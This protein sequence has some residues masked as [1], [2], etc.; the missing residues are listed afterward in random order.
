MSYTL[1]MASHLG[2]QYRPQTFASILGNNEQTNALQTALQENSLPHALL[3]SG[4]R[5]SGKTTLAR[6]V[7]MALSCLDPQKGQACTE[8]DVC[9]SP[10]PDVV[11]MDAA[12]NRGVD[13]IRAIRERV[14]LM[15]MQARSLV[16]IIDEA[17]MLTREA[18][19]AL[20]KTLEEPPPH[21]YFLLATT[22]P[23]KLLPT[24]RSRC[25]HV[26]IAP[27]QKEDIIK[28]LQTVCE[29]Q[30]WDADREGLS[31]LATAAAGSYRDAL[32]LLS[33]HGAGTV[34]RGSVQSL[35]GGSDISLSLDLC[36]AL[37]SHDLATALKCR[38]TLT[39]Q[40]LTPSIQSRALGSLIREWAYI[41]CLGTAPEESLLDKDA[42]AALTAITWDASHAA[43]LLRQCVLATPESLTELDAAIILSCSPSTKSIIV[44]DIQSEPIAKAVEGKKLALPSQDQTTIP[45]ADLEQKMSAKQAVQWWPTMRLALRRSEPELY[46]ILRTA[47]A[48]SDGNALI[49]LLPP[50]MQLPFDADKQLRHILTSWGVKQLL[51]ERANQPAEKAFEKKQVIQQHDVNVATA[52]S[53][54]LSALDALMEAEGLHQ[55]NEI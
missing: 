37:L 28:L 24:V 13:D 9:T 22:E 33:A 20:L 32:S 25:M 38:I 50:G 1:S 7:A 26:H 3:L 30:K 18:Q 29:D 47:T 11:E 14:A 46:I 5:G 36:I 55:A 23:E 48:R 15:P 41:H 39:E 53:V 6:I 4:T 27:A 44:P 21:V 49:V 12:S 16:W 35:L 8:C 52:P 17:H 42:Q 51:V 2:T 45:A 34:S 19:N 43:T 54:D 40:G 10:H 31:L